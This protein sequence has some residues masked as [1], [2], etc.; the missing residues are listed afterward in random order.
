MRS[1]PT[2]IFPPPSGLT[3]TVS[4]NVLPGQPASTGCTI[5]RVTITNGNTRAIIKHRKLILNNFLI[6]MPVSCYSVLPL[7][8][9]VELLD[10]K[11]NIV[12]A[13]FSPYAR[14]LKLASCL[15]VREVKS[16]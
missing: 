5:D 9:L 7:I 1:E 13:L 15:G 14:L 12:V 4:L 3:L 2:W 10:D 6:I 16:K 11:L 8:E